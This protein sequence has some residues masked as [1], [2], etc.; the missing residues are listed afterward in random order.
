MSEKVQ[1]SREKH[2]IDFSAQSFPKVA[3]T[4]KGSIAKNQAV[5]N[6]LVLDQSESFAT[7]K[8]DLSAKLNQSRLFGDDL[9]TSKSVANGEKRLKALQETLTPQAGAIPWYDTFNKLTGLKVSVKVV[10]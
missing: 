2:N 9:P 6:K 4:A 3:K 5:A 8:V 10:D 7:F 1:A